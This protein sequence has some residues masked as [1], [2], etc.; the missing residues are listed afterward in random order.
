MKLRD[1]I[2]VIGEG[3]T[4]KFYFSHLKQIKGYRY[5]I[6]PRFFSNNSIYYIAR[7]TENLLLA[8]VRVISVFDADVAQRNQKEATLLLHY[9]KKYNRNKNVIICDSLPSIEF[10]FLLHYQNINRVF[11]NY[12][13]IQ[14][15]LRK[16]IKNY[17]KSIKFLKN[18]EWVN[19]LA[20][21]QHIAVKNAQQL[22]KSASYSNIY[23]A[24]KLLETSQNF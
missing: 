16:H 6:R 5:T 8:D 1:S 13:S 15:E 3:E 18:N 11:S 20:S 22:S 2:F 19:A 21:L 4:E 24:V 23:K 10:W 7:Q 9:K 12:Q 14:R 17:D